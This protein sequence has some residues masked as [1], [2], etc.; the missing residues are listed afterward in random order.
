MR[1]RRRGPAAGIAASVTT[2]AGVAPTLADVASVG[3]SR[4]VRDHRY[5]Y[6]YPFGAAVRDVRQGG[7]RRTRCRRAAGAGV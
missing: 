6:R 4:G 2:F 7:G 1:E 3:A 5:G